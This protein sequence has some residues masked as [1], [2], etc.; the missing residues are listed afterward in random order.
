M[1]LFG[2]IFSALLISGMISNIGGIVHRNTGAVFPLASN[3]ALK[4]ARNFFPTD[5]NCNFQ[6]MAAVT[7]VYYTL[8]F[9]LQTCSVF[10][11]MFVA[12]IN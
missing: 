7:T 3:L 6:Q 10:L 2:H 8:K 4:K 12:F 1:N 9:T 5:D 11:T